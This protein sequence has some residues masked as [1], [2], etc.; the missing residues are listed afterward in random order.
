MTITQKQNSKIDLN[1]S[2]SSIK[3]VETKKDSVLGGARDQAA[4]D[5]SYNNHKL[6][7]EILKSNSV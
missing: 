1:Q 4:K 7:E 3:K 5:I 2:N 6:E